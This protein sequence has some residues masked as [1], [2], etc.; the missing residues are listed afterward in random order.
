MRQSVVTVLAL[1]LA[2][3]WPAAGRT[4]EPKGEAPRVVRIGAVASPSAV[5]VFEGVKRY[6]TKNG[7]PAD[8]VLYSNYDA[9]VEALKAGHVDI[10]WNTPLAHA[11][12]HMRCGGQSQALA[13]RDVDQNYRCVLVA[14]KGSGISKPAD[15]EGKTLVLGSC[16]AAEATVLPKH[17]LTKEGVSF[18]R[19]KVIDLDKE[20]DLKGRPC[21]S[22][23]HVL[24]A[25]VKGR[26]DAGIISEGMWKRLAASKS[27]E[28][29]ELQAVWTS[30]P[31]THCVFT[32]NKDFD[33]AL[34]AKFTKLML[35]MDPSDPLTAEAMRLEGTRKWLPGSQEGFGELFEALKGERVPK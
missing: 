11:R 32:A 6:L 23:Q 19:V 2:A 9:L 29:A 24:A 12:F 5:T 1:S 31:F 28:A 8:Y 20:R 27:T 35:A 34:G 30:P 3:L 7:L 26:G 21:S 22:P 10:A 17:F 13:M 33:K 18:E 14:R 4:A 15:L 16:H 25:L